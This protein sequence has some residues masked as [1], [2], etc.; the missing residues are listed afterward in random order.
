MVVA[1]RAAWVVTS[2][3]VA[4]AARMAGAA[5]ALVTAA[6]GVRMA[7]PRA[8]KREVQ[9]SGGAKA[10]A[11]MELAMKAAVEAERHEDKQSY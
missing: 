6:A 2:A 8:V 3:V 7:V 4:G 10:A 5:T 11:P 1:R 9:V